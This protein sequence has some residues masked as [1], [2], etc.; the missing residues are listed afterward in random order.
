MA[1]TSTPHIPFSHFLASGFPQAGGSERDV[2]CQYLARPCMV[3]VVSF[4]ED[5]EVP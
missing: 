5:L 4:F 1:K 2:L 3:F